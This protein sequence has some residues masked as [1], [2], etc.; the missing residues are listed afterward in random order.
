MTLTTEDG[1]DCWVERF[2]LNYITS[3]SNWYGKLLFAKGFLFVRPLYKAKSF[4]TIGAE[5]HKII[6]NYG[7]NSFPFDL[8]YTQFYH[9][10]E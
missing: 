5:L 4:F 8:S 7:M 1:S 10:G 2:L 6:S 3:K 9:F